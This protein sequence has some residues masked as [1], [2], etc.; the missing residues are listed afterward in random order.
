MNNNVETK[1]HIMSWIK[2][3]VT[4]LNDDYIQLKDEEDEIEF[5]LLLTDMMEQTHKL[6]AYIRKLMYEDYEN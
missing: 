5:D 6:E 4:D 3:L 1:A 2:Q